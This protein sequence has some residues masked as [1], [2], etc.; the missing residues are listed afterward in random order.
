MK[1]VEQHPG[2]CR[3]NRC[4]VAPLCRAPLRAGCFTAIC[5]AAALLAAPAR[6]LAQASEIPSAAPA[7]PNGQTPEQRGRALLD[8]MVAALGGR[9]WLD[10]ATIEQEGRTSS[11][12]HGQ[13]NLGVTDFRELRRLP[14]S[15][16]PEADRIEFGKKHDVIQIWTPDAGTEITYKG[17]GPL[18]REQVEDT[19]RRRAHSIEE[20]VRTW[21]DAPGV[22]VLSEGA[23]MVERRLADKVTV[24]SANNDAVTIELDAATHLPLRRTFEW[25]NQQFKDHDEDAEQYDDYHPVQ[26]LPTAMTITRY[27]NG[28]MATQRY[29][30]KVVY[31]AP[32]APALFDP[33]IPLHGKK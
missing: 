5:F 6:L 15:G 3:A 4:G 9:A 22:I 28:D 14:A 27:R 26:G 12:F 16:L 1:Q 7:A 32:L 23:T 20:V 19:L 2:H 24:L 25:R 18:P 13:P 17:I 33:T 21:I 8:Q 11:F 30:T 29:L 31:N 10:R